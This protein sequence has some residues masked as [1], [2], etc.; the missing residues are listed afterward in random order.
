MSPKLDIIIPG[1]C[2]SK[3]RPRT[4]TVEKVDLLGKKT[5]KTWGYTAK[6]SR[7]Y[8]LNAGLIAQNACQLSGF[9][10]I[11]Y[12]TPVKMT[13]EFTLRRVATA[14]PDVNNMASAILDVLSGIA[15][16]DD[17][18]VVEPV[19]NKLK[20]EEV[21]K[22]NILDASI[23]AAIA[24][25]ATPIMDLREIFVVRTVPV[26]VTLYDICLN[27]ECGVYYPVRVEKSMQK[28]DGTKPQGPGP[29]PPGMGMGRG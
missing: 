22:G 10:P 14:R 5:K 6:R 8:A 2:I 3:E 23:H 20:D 13:V 1:A 19:A 29:L 21:A 9:K 7:E 16:Y 26:L 17:S 24:Q 25:S 15:Y 18:Q 28:I 12:P 11:P 4:T 27:P